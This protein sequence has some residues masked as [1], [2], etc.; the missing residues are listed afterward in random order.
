MAGAARRAARKKQ[1]RR[2]LRLGRGAA[3]RH[4]TPGGQVLGSACV[5]LLC[6]ADEQPS[7][8]PR[9]TSGASDAPP[10]PCTRLC[11]RLVHEE[12]RALLRARASCAGQG[13]AAVQRAGGRLADRGRRRALAAGPAR[14][15]PGALAAAG[16]VPAGRARGAA[17]A[18]AA[19]P[20]RAAGGVRRAA[21]LERRRAGRAGGHA[22]PDVCARLQARPRAPRAQ[23]PCW[24]L[25][26]A[27]GSS[28]LCL[29]AVQLVFGMWWSEFLLSNMPSCA[30]SGPETCLQSA[31]PRISAQVGRALAGAWL[32]CKRPALACHALCLFAARP[33]CQPP[34]KAARRAL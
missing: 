11:R 26:V 8:A 4:C 28:A 12:A 2:G 22:G 24:W 21:V 7:I 19:V 16:A 20:G 15:R 5:T 18:L 14:G 27:P 29:T 33:L 13:P 32:A 17:L 3:A 31:A 9:A 10:C 34:A 6:G 30:S 23:T 25:P 1:R